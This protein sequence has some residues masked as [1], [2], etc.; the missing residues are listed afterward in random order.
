MYDGAMS[1]TR[2]VAP[3]PPEATGSGDDSPVIVPPVIAAAAFVVFAANALLS[4]D[5]V[6][7]WP[8]VNWAFATRV[9]AI[10]AAALATR[11]NQRVSFV[12]IDFT[13][14]LMFRGRKSRREFREGQTQKSG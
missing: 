11:A 6:R 14:E 4:C 13:R 8:G 9:V 3:V 10:N 2:V 5:A 1:P 12:V 7:I